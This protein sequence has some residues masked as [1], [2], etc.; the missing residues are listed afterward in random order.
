M[1]VTIGL[2]CSLWN[3]RSGL[4]R[5]DTLLRK[6]IT[7]FLN[8]GLLVTACQLLFAVLYLAGPL[9]RTW[10]FFHLL[11]SKFYTNTLLAILNAR[12]GLRAHVDHDSADHGA[13]STFISFV[14]LGAMPP[15]VSAASFLLSTAPNPRLCLPGRRADDFRRL[16][17]R[18]RCAAEA[19]RIR[20]AQCAPELPAELRPQHWLRVRWGQS[21]MTR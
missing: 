17:I 20:K 1:L 3:A 13:A 7:Y 6:L 12:G 8:R 10:I 14:P 11:L 16:D 2:C 5:T 9:E 19:Q 18:T 4:Q 21:R 15:S